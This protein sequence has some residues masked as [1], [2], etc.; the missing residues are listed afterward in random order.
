MRTTLD[1]ADGQ[2]KAVCK[3]F[4]ISAGELSRIVESQETAIE[5]Q[6]DLEKMVRRQ[7][8]T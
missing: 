7:S 2:V 1:L 3:R 5:K 4:S 8:A 6:V